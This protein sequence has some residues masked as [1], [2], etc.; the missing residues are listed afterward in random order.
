MIAYIGDVRHRCDCTCTCGNGHV[1]YRERYT[2]PMVS[3]EEKRLLELLEKID[4]VDRALDAR[5]AMTRSQ[6]IEAAKKAGRQS[7]KPQRITG[8]MNCRRIKR[9]S[10][11]G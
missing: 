2:K 9:S 4:N 10:A 11:K 5:I 3:P 6:R 8:R 7:T 1:V